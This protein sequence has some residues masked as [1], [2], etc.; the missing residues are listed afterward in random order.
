[1]KHSLNHILVIL[2]YSSLIAQNIAL[3]KST[4]A[5]SVRDNNLASYAVDGDQSTR[6]ESNWSDPQFLTVDLATIYS[7]NRIDIDW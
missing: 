1:M 7:I 3:Q 2:S 4:S 6:W 5:S